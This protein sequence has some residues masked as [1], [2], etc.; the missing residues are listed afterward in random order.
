MASEI[1]LDE[2]NEVMAQEGD[3]GPL[4]RLEE[5][6]SL[7]LARYQELKKQKDE[8]AAALDMEKERR[9]GLEKRLELISQDRDKVKTRID[10]L[11]HR[12]KGL[13]I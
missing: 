6:V 9:S 8:L 13:D 10:Q 3:G 12:L 11:L 7:L 1:S 4:E 2:R 5:K